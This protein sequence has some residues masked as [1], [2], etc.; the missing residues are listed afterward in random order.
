[1][2][3]KLQETYK[4]GKIAIQAG[5]RFFEEGKNVGFLFFDASVTAIEKTAKVKTLAGAV[6]LRGPS[7]AILVVLEDKTSDSSKGQPR[8]RVALTVQPRV[9]IGSLKFTEVVAGIHDGKT[10]KAVAEKELEQELGLKEAGISLADGEMINLSE[11]A[12]PEKTGT[13]G[14]EHLPAGTFPSVGGSDEYI[15]YF[16]LRMKLPSKIIDGLD[17]RETGEFKEGEKI[18]VKVVELPKL[19]EVAAWD[20]KVAAV[21]GLSRHLQ[22]KGEKKLEGLVF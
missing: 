7:V 4:L 17:G 14:D 22:S 15:V 8:Q 3:L 18:N 16:L 11:L 1:M 19:M 21:Y 6:F 5:Y 9:A 10:A 12:T 13:G 2:N 20:G